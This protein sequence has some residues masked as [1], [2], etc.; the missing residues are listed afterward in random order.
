[1]EGH[2][3]EVLGDSGAIN[4]VKVPHE[5]CR[6]RRVCHSDEVLMRASARSTL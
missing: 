2:I 1:M 5:A 4:F 6:C 3:A